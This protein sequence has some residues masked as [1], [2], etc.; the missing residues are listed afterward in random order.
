MSLSY[1]VDFI[2]KVCS[3]LVN[4]FLAIVCSFSAYAFYLPRLCFIHNNVNKRLGKPDF[5]CNDLDGTYD[6]GCGDTP[7]AS[8]KVVDRVQTGRD[9]DKDGLTGV[10]LI[11]GGRR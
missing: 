1:P 6:C 10:E 4:T 3:P 2:T 7:V 5:D 11:K 8:G 9:L